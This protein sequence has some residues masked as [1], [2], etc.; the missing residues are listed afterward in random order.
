VQ[1][2]AAFNLFWEKPMKLPHRRQFLQLAAGAA[3]LPAGSRIAKAQ[4]YPSRPV[5]I[6][7]GIGPGAAP[8]IVARLIAQW[9]SE[10]LGQ[11]FTVENRPGA[12]TNIAT[13]A[14]VR[15]TP[16]GYTLLDAGSA[17][18]IN[19]TLFEKLSFNF[20]Q[21]IAP[22]A[23]TTRMP[24][25][26]VVNPSFPAK[27]V[28][29][30]IAYAKANPGKI[31]MASPGIGTTPHLAGELFKMMTGIDMNYIPY[32]GG[33]GPA[34]TDL[35]GGQVQVAIVSTGAS[36]E[37]VRSGKLRPLATTTS[38]RLELLP[39]IPTIHEFVPGYEASGLFGIGAPRNTP[40]AIIQTL[41]KEINTG[42][43]DPTM[44]ARLHD[45]GGT[46]LPGSPA[47]FGRLIAAE[48]EKWGKVI[49]SAGIKPE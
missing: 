32:R 15:A 28:P 5:R 38:T 48:T 20:I 6:V 34:L 24:F 10:R 46:P 4:T 25:V 43:A 31:N 22:V 29:E 2:R 35:M 21:D 45:L 42:L 9:L 33:A 30:F 16:D 12:G 36:I 27:T 8:D 44:K 40:A 26:I 39:D 1:Q 14:V 23:S 37:L 41:N 11:P 19:A 47:D 13:D 49:K 17:Q 3:A 7:V 18:A